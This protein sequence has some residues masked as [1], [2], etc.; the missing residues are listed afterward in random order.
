ML[1]NFRTGLVLKFLHYFYQIIAKF[2]IF[3]IT[4][5]KHYIVVDNHD[6]YYDLYGHGGMIFWLISSLI[7]AIVNFVNFIKI[8][9]H[10]SFLQC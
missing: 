2:D 7:F 6:H 1:R 8:Y 4:K 9:R 3:H 5:D 10:F